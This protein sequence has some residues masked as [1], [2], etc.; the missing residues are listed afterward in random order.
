MALHI[1][2]S[3]SLEVLASKFAEK[4]SMN[5]CDPFETLHAVVPNSGM[6]TFLK[7][8]L[9]QHTPQKI[10]ANIETSFLQKFITDQISCYFT[11]DERSEFR[12]AVNSWSPDI[13]SWRIDALLEKA[14]DQH[15]AKEFTDYFANDPVKRHLLSCELAGNFD[16]YQL[17]RSGV[18]GNTELK[19]WRSGNGRGAQAEL[20]HRLC[21]TSPDPDLFFEKFFNA[22][23]ALE[24]LPEKCG[25]FGVSTISPLYFHCLKK[26]AEEMEIFLFSP[27]PCK[28]YWGDLLSNKELVREL[29]KAPDRFAELLEERARNNQLL[30]D[31]GV[32]GREFFNL[33]LNTDCFSS[34][35]G[36]EEIY[37][38]P[39]PEERGSALAI[40]QSDIL[41]ARARNSFSHNTVKTDP[42]DHSIRIN[43]CTD[44]R[45]ELE[46]LHDQL[47][48]LF[49]GK[50]ERCAGKRT[51]K[52]SDALRMEDVIVMFPDI[53]KAAPII[54]AV[55]SN[56]PFKGHYAICD[57]SSAGQSPVINCFNRL[58]DLP[59]SRASSEEILEL[60]EFECLNS[61]LDIAPESIPE[62]TDL[63]VRAKIS[64]GLDEKEH[65]KF[66]MASFHE[67]SWQDG[68]DR[69]LAEFAR[70]E[71]ASIIYSPHETGGI[72]GNL[73]RNLGSVAEFIALLKEWRSQLYLSRS[74]KEWGEFMQKWIGSFFN[75]AA[76]EYTPEI[77][78][79]KR[80]AGKVAANAAA[81]YGDTEQL[82]APEVF[83]SRLKS[84]YTL[85]GGKQHFLRDKI[86]FC[87]LV[88]LRAVPAKV[89]AVLGL[90]DGEFPGID[91][92]NSFD[93]LN[94]VRRND[95]NMTN[96]NRYLFLEALLAA[97]EN[98]ILSYIGCSNGEELAPAIPMGAVENLLHSGFGI[99]K[100]RVPLKSLE[101][102]SL[103]E[104][105]SDR[106][107]A[108][109]AEEKEPETSSYLNAVPP[110]VLSVTRLSNLLTQNCKEFCK[111]RC[112]FEYQKFEKASPATDDPEILDKQDASTVQKAL[113][114]MGLAG[115]G[116][117]LW[118]PLVNKRRFLPVNDLSPYTEAVEIVTPLLNRFSATYNAQEAVT[119][120]K[121]LSC[122]VT[123]TGTLAVAGT[124]EKGLERIVV[125]FSQFASE[126][127]LRFYLEQLLIAAYYGPETALS[128]KII[129]AKEEKPLYI[130]PQFPDPEGMLNELTETA[131]Q[132]YTA[133]YPLPLF[134]QASYEYAKAQDEKKS[135]SAFQKDMKYNKVIER[136]FNEEILEDENFHRLAHT[137][138][139][140]VASMEPDEL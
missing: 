57:R 28:E 56:G 4:L 68:I 64:W 89:I 16:R 98:L 53:N 22:P 59:L 41:N 42:S 31:F 94:K 70:G 2:L 39:A 87:S 9:A 44:A 85:T 114:T 103:K 12:N 140:A 32:S 130:M 82:I 1:F 86:T 54:D 121:K 107:K 96:D 127:L 112:G 24:K 47:L 124:P 90:N 48:E 79:L 108:E 131:L 123:L 95:P 71:D 45:R 61:K 65:E 92:R 10:A 21:R 88:P 14:K 62:L 117:S 33:L 20:Y 100:V 6:A 122:G 30:A 34:G 17:F 91:R 120:E 58:L 102:E 67:F 101:L 29:Q 46:I 49:Y 83:I 110:E 115:I 27:S 136:F 77:N 52:V 72:D 129:F 132:T 73:A 25:I 50:E 63:V 51:V 104:L 118:L 128:G 69:L 113:W 55:F 81:A 125:H 111:L 119:C 116:E 139:S 105:R 7:R 126:K 78:E 19:E 43:S 99:D 11:A 5:G 80:A 97:R 18:T 13:L 15:F 35:A 3:N 74:P 26:I 40:F 76:R 75:G 60:L 66:R 138:F 135:L 38:D 8:H 133:P 134:A 93:L 106:D 84:E 109:P 137:V 37:I 36:P 23:Q